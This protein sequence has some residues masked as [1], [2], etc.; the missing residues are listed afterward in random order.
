MVDQDETEVPDLEEGEALELP[1]RPPV[2]AKTD[3]SYESQ[4]RSMEELGK[5]KFGVVKRCTRKSDGVE[6]AAKFIK[7]TASSRA[8]VQREIEMMNKLHHK[9]LIS[10]YDAFETKAEMVVIMELVT[11]GELFEKVV[12]DDNLT[13]KQVIRY[14][15]Q[16]L[17]GVQHMHR[18][19]MV[20][21]D[22]KPE[23][24][25]CLGGCMNP[26]YEEIKLI[27]FGMT[28]VI[29]EGKQEAAICGTPEFVAPEVISFEPVTVC[30]DMWSM[31]VIV[32][33]LL[34]G[35]SPFM[36]DD[37]NE[38][39]QNVTS[40]EWD[41]DDGEGE[42]EEGEEGDEEEEDDD[43]EGYESVFA[44]VSD[45]C[46]QF[47]RELLVLDPSQR[48]TVDQALNHTWIKSGAQKEGAEKKIDIKNLRKFLARRRWQKTTNTIKAISRLTGGLNMFRGGKERMHGHEPG[49]FL[50][51]VKKQHEKEMEAE[52][53]Q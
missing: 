7:V 42:E 1:P 32:Y 26:G 43:E 31:G 30:A 15:K 20:H 2:Y 17:Y 5:G 8:E 6:L 4:Y 10:L 52:R 46:K 16:I 11:G 35:L 29:T 40:G 36:G 53:M 38:T 23:N 48:L 3:V 24:I 18:K 45:E 34:S 51:A 27:D 9:R 28:R 39:L 13:E 19:A 25:L 37:D 49:T 41:F 22:L 44:S 14:T 47:I 50:D 12:D 33:V 21:L